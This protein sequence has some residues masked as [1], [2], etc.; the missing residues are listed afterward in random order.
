MSGKSFLLSSLRASTPGLSGMDE[1]E[2]GEHL[3]EGTAVGSSY[4][5]GSNDLKA[6]SGNASITVTDSADKDLAAFFT[7]E[8]LDSSNY[9]NLRETE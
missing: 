4:W 9:Y 1:V 6:G 8:L 5:S 2:S 3:T 7:G